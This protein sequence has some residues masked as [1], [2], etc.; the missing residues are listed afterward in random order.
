[1]SSNNYTPIL[2]ELNQEISIFN[3]SNIIEE[4]VKLYKK[5]FKTQIN[6]HKEDDNSTKPLI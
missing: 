6:D 5:L 4:L 1:S 2:S 3:L